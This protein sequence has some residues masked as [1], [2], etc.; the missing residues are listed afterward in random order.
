MNRRQFGRLIRLISLL[1]RA[2]WLWASGPWQ[3]WLSIFSRAG[4]GKT[5][6]VLL[7]SNLSNSSI[8]GDESVKWCNG[9]GERENNLRLCRNA[10]KQAPKPTCQYELKPLLPSQMSYATKTTTSPKSH[11]PRNHSIPAD[12]HIFDRKFSIN[13]QDLTRLGW[14]GGCMARI[15]NDPVSGGKRRGF[16]HPI[17]P[18]GREWAEY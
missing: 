13:P 14:S 11:R 15:W 10:N 8:Y 18:I 1:T 6:K 5:L 9:D 12:S 16:L 4:N 3:T 2:P 7:D 17:E